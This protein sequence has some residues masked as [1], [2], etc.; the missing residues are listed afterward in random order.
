MATFPRESGLS[1]TFLTTAVAVPIVSQGVIGALA[2][3]TPVV[4]GPESASDG[5]HAGN[6]STARL[7]HATPAA[8]YSYTSHTAVG[9]WEADADLPTKDLNTSAPCRSSALAVLDW[10]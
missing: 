5:H 10:P 7:T 4:Q 8:L 2:Q 9:D 3:S 6:V 1:R